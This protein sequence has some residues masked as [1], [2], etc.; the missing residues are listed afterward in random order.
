MKIFGW[1]EHQGQR[2]LTT[3]HGPLLIHRGDKVTIIVSR[4]WGA[5]GEYLHTIDPK[6]DRDDG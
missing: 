2:I 6:R 4:E 1:E 3:P 5:A